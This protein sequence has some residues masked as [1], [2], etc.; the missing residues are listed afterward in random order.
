MVEALIASGRIADV[1]LA[2]LVVEALALIVRHRRTGRGPAPAA[3]LANA[4]AGAAL[5][6]ALKASL[7]GWGVPAVALFLALGGL[8]HG[9]DLWI[10]LRGP[11]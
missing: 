7:A 2:V 8:A 10:R 3:V 4:A 1:V 6:L 5:V 9:A 11:D